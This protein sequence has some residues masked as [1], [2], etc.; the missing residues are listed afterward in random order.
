MGLIYKRTSPSGK[1]YIG[2]TVAPE[3]VRW[4]S[5][6]SEALNER[7]DNCHLLNA[8][9]RK[10]GS[11]AFSVEILEDNI[12]EEILAERERYYIEKYHAYFLDA[13]YMGYNM[14]RGGE[15]VL[16]YSN[17]EIKAAW[18]KGLS[19][20][21]IADNVG[22]SRPIVR[23]RL[24]DMGVTEEE[25]NKRARECSSSR[26]SEFE[27]YKEDV[28]LLYNLNYTATQIAQKLNRSPTTIRK[29]LKKLGIKI[30][31]KTAARRTYKPVVQLDDNYELIEEYESITSAANIMHPN[32][33][34]SAKTMI[35][36]SAI[37][38]KYKAYGYHWRFKSDYEEGNV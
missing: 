14:T 17:V 10:Y 26:Q 16:K 21:Q 8:A 6:V 4:N 9:I 5:H 27:L 28:I 36:Q 13:P 24:R 1:Y 33:I 34:T 35:S 15:G 23:F 2:K 11:D 12:P 7:N 18:D 32:N 25:F 31:Q 3:N 22:C 29:Y 30:D 38:K 19:I 20:L 37:H